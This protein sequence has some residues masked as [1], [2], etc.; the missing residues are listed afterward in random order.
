VEPE[1]PVQPVDAVKGICDLFARID[2]TTSV[3]GKLASA[4]IEEIVQLVHKNDK[5]GEKAIEYWLNLENYAQDAEE[6]DFA[7]SVSDRLD[8]EAK[9]ASEDSSTHEN[10]EQMSNDETFMDVSECPSSSS[11]EDSQHNARQQAVKKI[12]EGIEEYVSSSE[13]QDPLH[14]MLLGIQKFLS[15]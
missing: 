2:V 9:S 5:Q 3:K 10:P 15:L 6:I 14:H 12:L 1:H 11:Q 7:M 13:A 8:Q 4:G